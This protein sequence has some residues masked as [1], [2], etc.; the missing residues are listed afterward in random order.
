M[1]SV[2]SIF[3]VKQDAYDK[4]YKNTVISIV[5]SVRHVLDSQ[6]ENKSFHTHVLLTVIA[7]LSKLVIESGY[8]NSPETVIK[9]S[10]D[11]VLT[12]KGRPTL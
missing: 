11:K 4:V 5:N 7:H 6:P 8:Y 3:K 1:S 12:E 9:N 2:V 10:I